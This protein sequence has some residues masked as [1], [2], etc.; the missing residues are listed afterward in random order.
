M[1]ILFICCLLIF[2]SSCRSPLY[3]APTTTDIKMTEAGSR[4]STKSEAIVQKSTE[5]TAISRSA[6][7]EIPNEQ[8][9]TVFKNIESLSNSIT[10]DAKD[11]QHQGEVI[12]SRSKG[13]IRISLTFKIILYGLGLLLIMSI[14]S[15]FGLDHF[16]KVLIRFTLA[17][18]EK[19]MTDMVNTNNTIVSCLVSE[20]LTKQKIKDIVHGNKK[21]K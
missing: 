9:K 11:I 6:R 4:V 2:C 21:G 1:K 20:D 14:L 16:V 3:R 12:I 19:L 17:P 18:V 5:I 8:A 15:Y 10:K 7:K 13:E